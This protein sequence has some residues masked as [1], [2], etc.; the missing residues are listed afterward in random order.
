MRRA[1]LIP[2]PRSGTLLK[3]RNLQR[4]AR[5][6]TSGST[7]PP[8]PPSLKP[9][10]GLRLMSWPDKEPRTSSNEPTGERD[11]QAEKI[12]DK[13]WELRVG[14]G[15]PS[16]HARLE[17]THPESITCANLIGIDKNRKSDIRSTIDGPSVLPIRSYFR[18]PRC[19]RLEQCCSNTIPRD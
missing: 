5:F 9:D 10:A 7:H 13:E 1:L 4:S 8:P 16:Q 17:R 18:F 19:F 3:T 12:T 11:S 6:V 2:R 15:E 14:K